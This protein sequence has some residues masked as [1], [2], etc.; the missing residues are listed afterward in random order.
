MEF[1]S[2]LGLRHA[3]DQNLAFLYGELGVHAGFAET[4]QLQGLSQFD[5]FIFDCNCIP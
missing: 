2:S 1:L 4:G 3:V 5:K